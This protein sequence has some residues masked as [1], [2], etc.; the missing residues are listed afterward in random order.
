MNIVSKI[1]NNR[2]TETQYRTIKDRLSY[3]SIK[4]Y[5]DSPL[6]FYKEHIL[7]QPTKREK[8]KDMIIGDGVDCLLLQGEEVFHEKFEIAAIGEI[9]KDQNQMTTFSHNLWD[10][11]L[12]AMDE[13][14]IITREFEHLLSDA[15]DRTKYGYNGEQLAFKRAGDTLEAIINKFYGSDCEIWYNQKRKTLHKT[16]LSLSDVENIEKIIGALKSAPEVSDIINQQTEGDIEVHNQ[17]AI[18]FELHNLPLKCLLDKVIID[19]KKKIIYPYDLKCTWDINSFEYTYLKYKYYIQN[20]VY[21]TGLNIWRVEHRPGYK[22][23]DF[24]FI[25]AHSANLYQPMIYK[26]DQT[27]YLKARTGFNCG[28]K[29]YKGVDRLLQEMKYSID[30]SSWNTA[31]LGKQIVDLQI[32]Y[33]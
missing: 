24:Q 32:N 27:D 31:P 25:V 30:N 19:H 17:F 15:Y 14:G 3:S 33:R 22:V 10:L 29:A 28:S 9:K 16:V 20:Y 5:D 18:L 26:T 4:T 8:S 1:P 2:I 13:E 6:D 21:T 7:L 11:T 23:A 12:E